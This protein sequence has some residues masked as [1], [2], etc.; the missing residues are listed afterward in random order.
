VPE[1]FKHAES[2]PADILK[3]GPLSQERSPHH[4]AGHRVVEGA[5]AS[6]D[7]RYAGVLQAA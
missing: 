7:G 5:W 4:R 3:G 1:F 2:D 6:G